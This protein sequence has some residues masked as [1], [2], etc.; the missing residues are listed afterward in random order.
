MSRLSSLRDVSSYDHMHAVN[1]MKTE[2]TDEETGRDLKNQ[3]FV[4][5]N[6][7][8]LPVFTLHAISQFFI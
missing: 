8:D 7:L 2:A 4:I 3:N 6:Y 1:G 5:T